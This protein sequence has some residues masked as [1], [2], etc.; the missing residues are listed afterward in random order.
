MGVVMNSGHTPDLSEQHSL[1]LA[2]M[3]Q[4]TPGG[5]FFA[6]TISAPV[7]IAH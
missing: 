3:L 4:G 1:W 5:R 6:K 7:G 2:K